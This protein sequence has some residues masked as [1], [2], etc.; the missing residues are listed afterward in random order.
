MGN[1]NLNELRIRLKDY[2]NTL[3][4]RN[5][6][7]HKLEEVQSNIGIKAIS[8]D[9]IGGS[10]NSISRVVENQAIKITTLEEQLKKVID[11]KE[12]EINRI[13]NALS[14]LDDKEKEIIELKHFKNHNWDT[15]AYFS[16]R[17]IKTCKKIERQALVKIDSILNYSVNYA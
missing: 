17:S 1:I 13:L 15:V 3:A 14:I 11:I 9:S 8:H 12:I 16:A 5:E 6:L 10:T 2:R 7:L 4:Q